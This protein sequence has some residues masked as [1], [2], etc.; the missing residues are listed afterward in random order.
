LERQVV[1]A[2][3]ATL[4]YSR[5]VIGRAANTIVHRLVHP[6]LFEA[7]GIPGRQGLAAALANPRFGETLRWSAS[8]A[9]S[10]F[11]DLGLIQGPARLLWRR[12]R[13]I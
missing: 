12:S 10:S 2:S 5:I 13:L 11:T 8:K 4:A 3:P 1:A 6:R 9:V 7:V